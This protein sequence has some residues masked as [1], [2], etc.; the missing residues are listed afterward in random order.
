MNAAVTRDFSPDGPESPDYALKAKELFD[1]RTILR[2]W[3]R[4]KAPETGDPARFGRMVRSAV[5]AHLENHSLN[6]QHKLRAEIRLLAGT[7]RRVLGGRPSAD[8]GIRA[9]EQLSPALR[10]FLD[11]RAGNG[12]GDSLLPSAKLRALDAHDVT[13][14]L[15]RVY[16]LL[17]LGMD[18]S[19][20]P[21]GA[22]QLR[23]RLGGPPA[24]LGR[25]PYAAELRLVG[26][27]RWVFWETTGRLPPRAVGNGE[28]AF[29]VF[30]AD[31]FQKLGIRRDVRSLIREAGRLYSAD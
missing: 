25:P 8:Y 1:D 7:L 27:L 11:A 3:Q 14:E 31:V 10:A 21:A 13:C 26:S 12:G 16:G 19:N 5:R 28:V 30:V 18:V 15:T 6:D 9:I 29:S 22:P 23:Q 20:M 4:V 24:R 2:L 17:V